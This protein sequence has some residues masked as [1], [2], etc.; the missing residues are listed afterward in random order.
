M[1]RHIWGKNQELRGNPKTK[2]EKKKMYLNPSVRI[3]KFAINFLA[4]G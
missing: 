3:I 4:K 1:S 2:R